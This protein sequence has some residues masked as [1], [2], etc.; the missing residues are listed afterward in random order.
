[1]HPQLETPLFCTMLSVIILMSN[2]A[3]SLSSATFHCHAARYVKSYYQQ[4][5]RKSP[6]HYTCSQKNANGC[7]RECLKA[8][9][10][11]RRTQ[12]TEWWHPG[13]EAAVVGRQNSPRHDE[14]VK[15]TSR[16][17]MQNDKKTCVH[18]KSIQ[19]R[20]L[21]KQTHEISFWI[22]EC[23]IMEKAPREMQTLRWL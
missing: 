21:N 14:P 22:T 2:S 13:S 17:H 19:N 8:R 4:M 7:S 16:H 9:L 20:L 5:W 15:Q 11:N 10:H 23:R 6:L 3:T 12:N 18:E 1:M